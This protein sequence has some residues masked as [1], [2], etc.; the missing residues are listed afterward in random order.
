MVYTPPP[1]GWSLAA[2]WWRR[3]EHISLLVHPSDSLGRCQAPCWTPPCFPRHECWFWDSLLFSKLPLEQPVCARDCADWPLG[4]QWWTGCCSKSKS[5]MT[6]DGSGK[7]SEILGRRHLIQ[8]RGW[9]ETSSWMKWDLLSSVLSNHFLS[10]CLSLVLT[11]GWEYSRQALL[12][13]F[14]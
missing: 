1:R 9:L 2:F 6:Q 8:T 4:I 13:R 3:S 10:P 11:F 14:W 7:D 12:V 5:V